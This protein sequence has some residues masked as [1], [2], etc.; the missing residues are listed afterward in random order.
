MTDLLTVQNLS[1]HYAGAL[2]PSITDVSFSL[3]AGEVIGVVGESGSGKT[4]LGL[5]LLGLLPQGA[6][7]EGSAQFESAEILGV[8][9][10]ELRPLRGTRLSTIVQNPA[11]ALNPSFSIGSQ[12]VALLRRHRP[13]S[14]SEA[15]SL[16]IEW[17]DRVGISEPEKRMDSY[18]H[19]LSGGMN[20]RVVIAMALALSPRLVIADEPTSALDVTVQAAVLGLI[21][22]LIDDSGSSMVL[23]THDLGVIAQMCSRVIVMK[24]GRV[25]EVGEVD[26]IFHAPRSDYTKHLL[27]SQP[28]HAASTKSIPTSG[29]S[30]VAVGT[31]ES[32]EEHRHE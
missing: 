6:M 31:S 24:D 4:T 5:A 18:S 15:R 25:L 23:I 14:K 13:L 2:R 8:S 7:V 1:V 19:Q 3:A 29:P 28:S 30:G 9:E 22:K 27:A 26:Q 20:Q 10:R 17:L 16:A 11:T 32:S 21:T 12:I